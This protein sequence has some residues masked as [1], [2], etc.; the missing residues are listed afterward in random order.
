[1]TC[2]QPNRRGKVS[3]NSAQRRKVE[4]RFE[5]SAKPICAGGVRDSLF[6]GRRRRAFQPPREHSAATAFGDQSYPE[7]G[8]PDGQRSSGDSPAAQAPPA[9]RRPTATVKPGRRRQ[10]MSRLRR[11]RRRC[12][13][14][15]AAARSAYRRRPAETDDRSI[16][17]QTRIN[18]RMFVS[19]A[20][21]N[22]CAV[23]KKFPESRSTA[24]RSDRAAHFPCSRNCRRFGAGRPEP[25]QRKLSPCRSQVETP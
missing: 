23:V 16:M 19:E 3:E 6:F 4:V 24:G 10:R 11:A 14:K 5:T 18:R 2:E 17:R 20:A 8:R 7:R 22:V 9:R 15:D 12:R 21:S 13:F 25:A 1:M